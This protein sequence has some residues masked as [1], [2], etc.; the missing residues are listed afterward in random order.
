MSLNLHDIVRPAITFNKADSGFTVFRSVGQVN[1]RGVITAIYE[2][3]DG[4][5]GQFQSE[6]DSALYH[7]DLG[8][9]S[10]VIRKLYLYAPDNISDR[11]WSV[12][13][14]QSRSGDFIRD[15]K[16][17][18]WL[19]SAVLEDFSQCGWEC[20]RVTLQS[21][22]PSIK[23]KDGND[24]TI[25]PTPEPE[26]TPDDPENNSDEENTDNNEGA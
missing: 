3:Y 19:V 2:R 10:T 22:K 16:G 26:P 5:K 8:T 18:Y 6:G 11:V 1:N 25:D 21:V 23:D 14:N 9:Q 15:D 12:Y 4:F 13:R 17:E 24:L 7:A 20:V